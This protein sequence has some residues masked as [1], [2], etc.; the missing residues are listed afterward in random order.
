M[1]LDSVRRHIELAGDLW[2]GQLVGRYRRTRVSAWLIGSRRRCGSPGGA[3]SLLA[4]ASRLRT[5]AIS[6]GARGA[7]PGMALEQLRRRVDAESHEHT[8][9]PGEIEHPLQG[10]PGGGRVAER[11]ACRRLQQQSRHHRERLGPDGAVDDGRERGSRR[12]RIVLGKPQ[13]RQ[14]GACLWVPALVFVQRGG[15]G[16][17]AFGLARPQQRLQH[18]RSHRRREDIRRDEGGGQPLAGLEVS[19]RLFVT[20]KSEVEQAARIVEA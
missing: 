18:V 20:A 15:G 19:Q 17:D 3:A 8:V 1:R 16:F 10:A 14:G 4:A 7:L 5:P 6:D 9:G 12:L 11:V 13:R 2:R